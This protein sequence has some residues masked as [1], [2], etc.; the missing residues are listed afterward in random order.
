MPSYLELAQEQAWRDE[1]PAPGLGVLA[2]QLRAFYG[3]GPTAIGIKGDN[4]HLRGGHRSRRWIKTS[5]YCTDRTFTVSRTEGDRTGGDDDWLV[6]L[7]IGGIG[8]QKLYDMCERLDQAARAGRIEKVIEWY[9]TFDGEKVVGW[10]NIA[11]RLATADSSHLYHAHLRLD[12]GKAGGNH[13]DLF[14]ILTGDD[15]ATPSEIWNFLITDTG[16]TAQTILLRGKLA[17]EAASAKADTILARLD[18]IQAIIE[19]GSGNPDTAAI[20]AA[21]AELKAETRDA[22]ADLGEGGATQVRADL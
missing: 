10:D 7:D 13:N 8:Q 1:I 2:E 15:M 19:A 6:A 11:N 20:L 4:R 22:V 18:E 9:G 5:A 21:I 14:E 17:A 16:L 3:V 12:R